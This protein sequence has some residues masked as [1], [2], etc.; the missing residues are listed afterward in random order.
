MSRPGTEGGRSSRRGQQSVRAKRA[1]DGR[2]LDVVL[3]PVVEQPVGVEVREGEVKREIE[4]TPRLHGT[5][6][7]RTGVPVPFERRHT[8][9]EGV[10]RGLDGTP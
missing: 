5:T 8:R 10:R 6:V 7:E 1:Q 3:V 9:R 2:C 4:L